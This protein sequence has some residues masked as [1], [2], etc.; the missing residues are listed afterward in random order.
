MK[1]GGVN[2]CQNLRDV[3]LISPYVVYCQVWPRR[4]DTTRS[5]GEKQPGRVQRPFRKISWK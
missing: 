4:D 5:I 2:I 3:F 1:K